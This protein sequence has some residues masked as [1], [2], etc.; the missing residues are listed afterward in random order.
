MKVGNIFFIGD[1][2]CRCVYQKLNRRVAKAYCCDC[3]IVFMVDQDELF[4]T[5][6]CTKCNELLY[7][8]WYK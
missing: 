5:W 6:K 3:K 1:E 2:R 8:R 4:E 7:K